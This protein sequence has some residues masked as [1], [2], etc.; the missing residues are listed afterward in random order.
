MDEGPWRLK[1]GEAFL[2]SA[3]LTAALA[4]CGV[5]AA[6]PSPAPMPAVSSGAVEAAPAPKT[7]PCAQRIQDETLPLTLRDDLAAKITLRVPRALYRDANKFRLWG[8]RPLTL[9]ARGHRRDL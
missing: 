4:G 6:D 7:I 9:R 8:V 5:A 2:R 3:L 1:A